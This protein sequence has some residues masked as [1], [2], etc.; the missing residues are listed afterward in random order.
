M[1]LTMYTHRSPAPLSW[2]IPT[3]NIWLFEFAA[4]YRWRR[5]AHHR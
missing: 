5:K 4:Q 1:G 3:Y 2:F